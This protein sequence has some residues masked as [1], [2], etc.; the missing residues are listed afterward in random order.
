[1]RR[2]LWAV[3]A[4]FIILAQG[5]E[6][7][8]LGG[9]AAVV[10]AIEDRRTTGT[11][12]DD[13]SIETRVRRAVRERY[14][15]ATHVNVTSFNRMVLLTG[16]VPD[17]AAR[18]D[19]E[20][21]AAEAGN[22]RGIANELQIAPVSTLGARANDGIITSRVKARLLDGNKVNPV[23]V[24]V[25]T[26]AAVVYLLGLVSEQEADEAVEVART[27]GG[28]RKVVKIFE[29][30]KEGDGICRPFAAPGLVPA[31]PGA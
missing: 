12:F 19:I 22:V 28:V 30:C 18:A 8:L 10:S 9:G 21:L 16:E 3:F 6:L 25:V 26:E 13:D 20:R 7:A 15:T 17:E 11:R 27:T 24:K 29:Y 2:G 23:H 14:G 4:L 1:M 5:C 31:P